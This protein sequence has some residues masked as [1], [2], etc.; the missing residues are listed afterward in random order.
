MTLPLIAGQ[1]R[2]TA[3]LPSI[4]SS[5]PS[6]GRGVRWQSDALFSFSKASLSRTLV[7][8]T[9]MHCFFLPSNVNTYLRFESRT[10]ILGDFFTHLLLTI[11]F[12][13]YI[14][15]LFS[16]TASIETNRIMR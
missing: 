6:H 3:Q 5:H 4:K 14:Y 11:T 1:I 7:I 9:I 2:R 8:G 16:N 15:F 13:R 12:V 10:I